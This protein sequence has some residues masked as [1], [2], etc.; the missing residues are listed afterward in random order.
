MIVS[1]MTREEVMN[2]LDKIASQITER[3]FAKAKYLLKRP[4]RKLPQK[5]RSKYMIDGHQTIAFY[6]P[7]QR[8]W[9]AWIKFRVDAT[10]A[11]RI[12]KDYPMYASVDQMSDGQTNTLVFRK[13]ALDRYNERLHLGLNNCDDILEEIS[14]KDGACINNFKEVDSTLRV[15]V[16]NTVNG[17]FLGYQDT[18]TGY[19]EVYTFITNQMMRKGQR[20]KRKDVLRQAITSSESKLDKKS[21]SDLLAILKK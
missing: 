17:V 6:Y 8:L 19:K 9:S 13:H 21:I 1:R 12:W 2:Q 3:V 5:L 7:H 4:L 20:P 15:L 11:G 14:Y 16:A 10:V 18:E